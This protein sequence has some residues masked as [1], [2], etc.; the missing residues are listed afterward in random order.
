MHGYLCL[1]FF[2]LGLLLPHMEVPRLRVELE[3]QLPAYAPAVATRDPSCVCDLHYSSLQCQKLNPLGETRDRTLI[4]MDTS[5]TC[6]PLSSNGNSV[7]HGLHGLNSLLET[8]DMLQRTLVWY[9]RSSEF[10]F[11]FLPLTYCDP[12]QFIT[13]NSTGTF[14][15]FRP[16]LWSWDEFILVPVTALGGFTV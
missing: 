8:V 6:N 1:L 15:C 7:M 14:V 16:C 9:S 13:G 4:L 5:R 2:F 3:L 12:G 10:W 11:L